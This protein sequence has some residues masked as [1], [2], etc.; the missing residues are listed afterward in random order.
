MAVSG[1]RSALW[2][3]SSFLTSF[4][5]NGV[6]YVLYSQE[7]AFT[8]L[9]FL[10][11]AEAGEGRQGWISQHQCP[12]IKKAASQ[13]P[14]HRRAQSPFRSSF[15]RR[16]EEISFGGSLPWIALKAPS[17]Y[18]EEGCQALPIMLRRAQDKHMH[19]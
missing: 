15:Q 19:T 4:Q 9:H 1:K 12:Q 10:T 6:S 17:N 2:L 11:G 7:L 13:F 3:S 18:R 14:W 8:Q 5:T 16:H